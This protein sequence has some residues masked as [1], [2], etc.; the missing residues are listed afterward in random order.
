MI[1]NQFFFQLGLALASLGVN[2]LLV[3]QHMFSLPAYVFILCTRVLLEYLN[4]QK[5]E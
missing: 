5:R 3:A 4:P 1:N 2:T